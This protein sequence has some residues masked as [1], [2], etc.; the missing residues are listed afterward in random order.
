METTSLIEKVTEYC[1]KTIDLSDVKLNNEYYYSCLPLCV[2]DSVFSI[3][4]KYEGVKNTLKKL[5]NYLDIPEHHDLESQFPPKESQ[6]STSE[7]LDKL[8]GK[9]PEKLAEEVFQNRQRT[10]TRSGI[11]KTEAV[12]RFLEVLKEFGGEYFQ[13]IPKL[14]DDKYFEMSI[15]RI[16]GQKSGISLRYFFILAGEPDFIKPDRMIFRF[17]ES[18]TG[19]TVS[20]KESEFLLRESVKELNNLGYPLTARVL[21]NKIWQY[22]RNQP[23]K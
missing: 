6:I 19:T 3:G 21:D 7:F 18:A 4:V 8:A 13:D 23:V 14:R 11:L 2:V 1:L 15:E 17:L 20:I 16:P 5:C 22:Q 12:V 10:S 9:T